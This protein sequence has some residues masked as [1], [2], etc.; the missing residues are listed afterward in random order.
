MSAPSVPFLSRATFYYDRRAALL[1][2]VYGAGLGLLPMVAKK[3]FHAS[4]MQV[5]LLVCAPMAAHLLTLYWGHFVHQRR[6]MPVVLTAWSIGRGL[7]L[8]GAFITDLWPLIVLACASYLINAAALPAYSAIWRHNYPTEVRG[9]LVS[10][11][12]RGTI[13]VI[14]SCSLLFGRLLDLN[15]FIYRI[16]LPVA[17]ISGVLAAVVF[18]RVRVRREATTPQEEREPFRLGKA[19]GLLGRNPIFGKYLAAFFIS[20]FAS[21]M[22]LPMMVVFINDR[23]QATYLQQAVA[24]RVLPLALQLLLLPFWGR[25]ADRMSPMVVRALLSVL[26]G[27]SYLLWA[28]APGMMTIYGAQCLRGVAMGGGTLIWLLGAM[29]FAPKDELPL[30]M[31]LHTTLTGIRGVIAPFLGAWLAER[32]GAQPLFGVSWLLC[33]MS[34]ALMILL[35]RRVRQMNRRDDERAD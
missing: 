33:W 15:P 21:M 8:L 31:G 19:L 20:G 27:T 29:Y 28:V 5:A 11:V 2:G 35:A 26:W 18:R 3:T 22:A 13:L 25:V 4:N 6:K 32:I 30:Y 34:A 17:G 14:A 24:L 12:L 16:L 9:Q 7:L 23:F 10:R 1:T